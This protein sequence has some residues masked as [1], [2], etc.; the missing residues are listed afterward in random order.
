[1]K[2]EIV[3]TVNIIKMKPIM[4]FVIMKKKIDIK[5]V[6]MKVMKLFNQRMMIVVIVVMV[7]MVMVK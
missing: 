7:I 3:K 1:M 2:V 6:K 4:M 5:I